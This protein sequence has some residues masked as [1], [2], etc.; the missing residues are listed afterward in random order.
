MGNLLQTRLAK[1]NRKAS[2]VYHLLKAITKHFMNTHSTTDNL[3]G[4]FITLYNSNPENP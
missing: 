1:L 4:K 2:L 3:M